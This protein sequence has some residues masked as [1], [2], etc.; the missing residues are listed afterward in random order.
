MTFLNPLFLFSL[1]AVALPLIVHIFS[2]R[3]IREIRFSTLRFLESSQR[4]SMRSV[5]LRRLLL[6]ALRMIAVALVA[7]AFS[8]P[9]IKGRVASLFPGST[10]VA[11]CILIDRSYS[12][13][14]ET[15]NGTLLESALKKAEEIAVSA[16]D[17]DMIIIA[18]MDEE[19]RKVYESEGKGRALAAE[20]IGRIGIS[21]KAT[22]LR[23]GVEGAQKML[24]ETG[25]EARE[26]YIIS[27]FQRSALENKDSSQRTKPE[28]RERAAG[29]G[30][31]RNFIIPVWDDLGGNV[32][33][34]D[35]LSPSLVIH[36]GEI[37]E[38]KI[39]LRNGSSGAGAVSR[40]SIFIEGERIINKE[41]TLTPGERKIEK[42]AFSVDKTGWIRGEVRLKRD[43]LP[44]DDRRFFV[45]NA[46]EK[47]R[48]LLV[49]E[50]NGFYLK[51][52]VSPEGSEGDMALYKP[53]IMGITSEAVYK[54]DVIVLG[55]G[56]ALWKEDIEIIK[57]FVENGGGALIFVRRERKN[58]IQEISLLSPEI[59]S[60][61]VNLRDFSLLIPPRVPDLL[62]PFSKEEIK[63]LSR[64][65]FIDDIFVRGIPENAILL[66]FKDRSPFIWKER[67]GKG[68][69]DFIVFEPTLKGGEFVV[70]PYFLPVVQQAIIDVAGRSKTA[71]GIIVGQRAWWNEH[72]EG[73]LSC[74]YSG[75]SGL[76]GKGPFDKEVE[77]G[78]RS[79][80]GGLLIDPV[81]KPG[82][83]SIKGREGTVGRIA[84]NP[85]A[86]R[87]PDLEYME[88]REIA[89]SLGLGDI[90]FVD[91]EENTGKQLK[92][93]KE[94][95]EISGFLIAAAIVILIIEILIAQGKLQKNREKYVG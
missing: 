36:K 33:I 70:S 79:K 39:T 30:K 10:P 14:V 71:G 3:R 61:K 81:S 57:G 49:G 56:K 45:L 59:I 68:T 16:K 74:F 20:A 6:L 8:R 78:F 55:L 9:V 82:F 87:E 12:M 47:I 76:D 51:Q 84:V 38:L 90:A 46:A 54:A 42:V 13:G 86:R 48:V 5:K 65:R 11:S 27:D 4:R 88:G 75:A 31:A 83:I 40:M 64:V 89:D 23:K 37:I 85:E 60:R 43:K 25:Y 21:W 19:V 77:I 95:R 29:E 66:R 17:D 34:E 63:G 62:L 18:S 26:L 73:G 53:D 69:V 7:L 1:L 58:A 15:E 72:T 50:K 67:I 22:D 52:A 94:G 24:D 92:R 80:P 93:A 28:K 2:R 35:I 32:T 41:I 91:G 44:F